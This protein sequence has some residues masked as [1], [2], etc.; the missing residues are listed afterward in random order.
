MLRPP[1]LVEPPEEFPVDLASVKKHLRVDHSD[2]DDTIQEALD[3]GVKKLDGYSGALG[4]A[5][6][7]QTWS[8]TG[9]YRCTPL[10]LPLAP[11][12]SAT[13]S[14]ID[15]S[16]TTVTVAEADTVLDVDVLGWF[17]RP[18]TGV[19][20]PTISAADNA[21]KVVFIAGYGDPEAVPSDIRLAIKLDVEMAYDRPDGERFKALQ[22][23]YDAI[24]RRNRR[25]NL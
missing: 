15:S 10:R 6:V 2:D 21:V 12:Q 20:W 19:Y 17:V 8:M 24:V 7:T 5:L 9:S 23:Q 13:V 22:A 14:Y 3:A 1:I 11:V 25:G 16:G 18:K 4:R